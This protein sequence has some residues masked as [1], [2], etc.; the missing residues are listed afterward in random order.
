[1]GTPSKISADAGRRTGQDEQA[2]LSLSFISDCPE[3]LK[4]VTAALNVG[5]IEIT[6]VNSPRPVE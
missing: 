2:S 6:D 4:T 5:E 3:R 1:M